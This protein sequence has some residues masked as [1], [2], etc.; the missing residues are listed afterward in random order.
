MTAPAGR[1]PAGGAGG[2]AGASG[3]RGPHGERIYLGWQYAAL[4]PDPG[5]PPRRPTPPDREQLNPAW[6]AAQRR[7][8]SLLN[9][10][11]KVTCAAAAAI[12]VMLLVLGVGG[13]LNPVV[14][15]LGM[16]ICLLAAGMSGYA[17]WQGERALRER[18]ADER[19][20]V[21]KF[22]AD[23]ESKLFEW[24]AEHA[25]QVR[26]WQ[27]RRFAYDS[28][29]R[30]YAVS[31]PGGIDRVDV[32][33]GTLP[34]WG[35]LL[36]TIGAYRLATGGEVA[37][38][39]LSGGAVARDLLA[40]SRGSGI[41]PLVWVLP[42]DLPTLDLGTRLGKEALADVLSLVV[43]VGE[44]HTSTRELSFDNAILE[45]VIDALGGDVSLASVAAALRVLAQAG[46]PADD[47]AAGLLSTEQA[48]RISTLFGQGAADRVVLERAW[49]LE[50]QLRKLQSAGSELRRLPPSRL[51]VV[52]LDPRVG[53]LSGKI[54]GTY[55]LTALTHLLRQARPGR[56]WQQTLFVLGAD[57]LRGDVLDRLTD[58]CENSRTGL[59]L[60]YRTI[61]QQV[62][63]RLGRGNAA[64][65]FMRLGNAEDAR[66]A[67][68][69]I[70]T[71][72][73]FV[74][75]QLTETIGTSVTD[76]SGASYTSTV[77][78]SGSAA[79]SRSVN[80]SAGQGSGLGRSTESSFL[81]LPRSTSSRSREASRS[82]GTGEAESIT[83]G[84]STSTAWGVSTSLAAGDS[85][86]LARSAQRS[87]EFLVEQH[88]LQQLPPSAVII[89]Y[90]SAAG[91][92]V[93]MADANPGIASLPAAT[94]VPLAEASLLGTTPA[95]ARQAA[96]D[97]EA[98]GD[99]A[100]PAPSGTSSPDGVPSGSSTPSAQAPPSRPAAP[101]SWR[102]GPGKRPPP[103]LGPPP[104]RLDWRKQG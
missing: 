13:W 29:K 41:H 80:E 35:A 26:E 17:V 21:E 62:K 30:W 99:A 11:L 98:G 89:S 47:V 16:I 95:P 20:R 23:Q 34:G 85:E 31:L 68:E 12:A 75:S 54:L 1:G 3:P 91:R 104:E 96:R 50:S 37:V 76:T 19:R 55:V 77:G 52:A 18:V 27:A 90:A 48:G 36:T 73:K 42:G 51:R 44:E 59:V 22:R 58:A 33:G 49:G 24:Q 86:S 65:A 25:R 32:A 64:V 6:V 60:A 14:A 74:L 84:I 8:E 72:H 63:E 94:M 38:L 9:R 83:A 92:Q 5:P 4:H 7:E 2:S 70:G 93:V 69:Q 61:P 57:K 81:P 88:E 79:V 102:G 45:R 87:R 100:Q 56:P 66:A 53:V 78:S 103:N 28:Q 67:S 40:A 71:E 82:R 15:A 43:S 101:V 46:D 39:D 10:P 97:R